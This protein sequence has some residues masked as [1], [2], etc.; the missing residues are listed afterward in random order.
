M[1]N[2]KNKSRQPQRWYREQLWRYPFPHDQRRARQIRKVLIKMQLYPS[3]DLATNDNLTGMEENYRAALPEM[4]AELD[5]TDLS[6][7]TDVVRLLA[8][9]PRQPQIFKREA[10]GE[11][12]NSSAKCAPPR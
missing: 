8:L 1:N 5:R 9:V 7:V 6:V 2:S 12:A 11:K 3:Y 4:I 10:G